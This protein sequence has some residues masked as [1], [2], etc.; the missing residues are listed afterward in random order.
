MTNVK[1]RLNSKLTKYTCISLS[2]AHYGVFT[3]R[4]YVAKID[5]L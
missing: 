3:V 2:Q 1:Y 4:I 5:L